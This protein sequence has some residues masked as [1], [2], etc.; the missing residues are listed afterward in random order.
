MKLSHAE[1]HHKK[2]S[3]LS[4]RRCQSKILN[5][6][7]VS[8]KRIQNSMN[9]LYPSAPTKCILSEVVLFRPLS[10]TVYT[11][12]QEACTVR[13]EE[14]LGSRRINLPNFL[15][16]TAA[17]LVSR[18]ALRQVRSIV[19]LQNTYKIM[20]V[21]VS[22]FTE[23]MNSSFIHSPYTIMRNFSFYLSSISC[24]P[25][26]SGSPGKTAALSSL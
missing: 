4:L 10:L 9:R 22:A 6:Y 15:G 11:V 19:L 26:T 21:D 23:M 8:K 17:G 2:H 12:F 18:D 24:P 3:Y 16:L 20:S 1:S 14:M 13:T 7:L 25:N 5:I